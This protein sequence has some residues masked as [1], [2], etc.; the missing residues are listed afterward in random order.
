MRIIPD[1]ISQSITVSTR[2]EAMLIQI[3]EKPFFIEYKTNLPPKP[4]NLKEKGNI[5]SELSEV[6][7]ET[8]KQGI[9]NYTQLK[10]K[11]PWLHAPSFLY[12]HCVNQGLD[13]ES[14]NIL[15]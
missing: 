15:S 2:T 11:K 12:G 5:V 8:I 1:Y 13:L 4:E 3:K 10:I 14:L 7:F 9:N 6:D